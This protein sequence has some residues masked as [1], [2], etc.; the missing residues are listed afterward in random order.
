MTRDGKKRVILF[1]DGVSNDPTVQKRTDSGWPNLADEAERLK[2]NVDDVLTFEIGSD[3]DAGEL[4]LIASS[5]DNWNI[6]N[7]FESIEYAVRLFILQQGGCSTD[8]V[9]PFRKSLD[10]KVSGC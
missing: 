2:S 9:K 10:V 1:T 6:L 7:D 8:K 4:E 3:V 5:N